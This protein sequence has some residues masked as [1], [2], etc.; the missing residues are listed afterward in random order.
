V[1]TD[2]A[3]N[4]SFDDFLRQADLLDGIDIDAYLRAW[5]PADR[6]IEVVV[7]PR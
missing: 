2:P 6:Y 4:P 3:G 5:L 7:L 1:L